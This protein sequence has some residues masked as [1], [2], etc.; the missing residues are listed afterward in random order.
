MS[1]SSNQINYG[2]FADNATTTS[3]ARQLQ[4]PEAFDVLEKSVAAQEE[5]CTELQKRLD[6]VLRNEPEMAEAGQSEPKRTVVGVASRL[7]NA[8]DRLHRLANAYNSILKRL[9]L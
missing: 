3:P 2:N 4:V 7:N 1:T 5:L 8:S 9:E 6:G